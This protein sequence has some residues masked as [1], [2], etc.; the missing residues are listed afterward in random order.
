MAKN[1][2]L[3]SDLREAI[4]KISEV[5]RLLAPLTSST[6]EELSSSSHEAPQVNRPTVN[7]GVNDPHSIAPSRN[8]NHELQR[9]FP[10]LRRSN[11]QTNPSSFRSVEHLTVRGGKKR[12]RQTSKVIANC[13]KAKPV[14]KDIVLIPNPKHDRVPTHSARLELERKGLVIHE[15]SLL[16]ENGMDQP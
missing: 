15:Y 16:T 1:G 8:V 10:T 2:N 14:F 6:F 3:T 4:S 13:K 9:L 7:S 11:E 5:G 12:K